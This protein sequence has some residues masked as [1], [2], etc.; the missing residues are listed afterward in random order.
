MAGAFGASAPKYSMIRRSNLTQRRVG[1]REASIDADELYLLILANAEEVDGQT[2][3]RVSLSEELRRRGAERPWKV[4]AALV[5]ELEARGLVFRPD[6]RSRQLV[7]LDRPAPGDRGPKV[8]S[9]VMATKARIAR[10]RHYMRRN[11]LNGREFICSSWGECEG[12]IGVGCTFKE[13]QLSHV[14]KHYDLTMEGRSLRVVVVGQE[15]GA[16]AEPRVTLAQRYRHIHRG[17]GLERRFDGDQD[18]TR[19]NPHMRGTTLALRTIFCKPGTGH[20][21]EFLQMDGEWVHMFDCFALVNRLLCAAHTAG[22][23]TGR[24]TGTMLSNCERHFAATLEILDP[25]IVVIQG[26]RVWEWS[27][28]IL[29]A[30]N[31]LAPNLVECEVAGRRVLVAT[32]THPSAWGKDRWDSPGSLYMTEVV[33]PT[34]DLAVA[35]L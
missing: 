13:G 16:T 20:A 28:R 22:T 18:H 34:L 25:T 21:T 10:L 14:G 23:S 7:I 26:K 15:V 27:Q 8:R 11:V 5:K 32:F 1:D 30:R 4:R 29:V 33:G 12:S 3:C 31:N 17:S 19:R 2:I 24:S 6:P 9:D 35:S